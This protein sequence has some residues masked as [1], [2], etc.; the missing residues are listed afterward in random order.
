METPQKNN[1][2]HID[3]I[4]IAAGVTQLDMWAYRPKKLISNETGLIVISL[5]FFISEKEKLA[6]SRQ[7][8]YPIL[9]IHP[10]PSV[11]DFPL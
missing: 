1:P 6:M 5:V 2:H 11:S 7:S 9:S 8:P 3:N 4:I 10:R